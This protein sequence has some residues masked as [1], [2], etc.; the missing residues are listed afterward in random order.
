LIDSGAEVN[1]FDLEWLR[2]SGGTR[3]LKVSDRIVKSPMFDEVVDSTLDFSTVIET[4]DSYGQTKRQHL[5]GV[6]LHMDEDFEV[7]LG[8]PWLRAVNPDVDWTGATWR[9]RQV[10][11]R[12]DYLE[13]ITT[14]DELRRAQEESVATI[15][16]SNF[17]ESNTRAKEAP[18]QRRDPLGSVTYGIAGISL[19]P[20]KDMMAKFMQAI[21]HDPEEEEEASKDK[22]RPSWWTEEDEKFLDPQAADSL[23]SLGGKTHS[24]EI[25]GEIPKYSPIYPLHPKELEALKAYIEEALRKGWIRRSKSP[26]GAPIL[27]VPKKGGTLRLCIDYRQLN[28]VT[29]KDRTPLPLI[30][31]ILERLSGAIIY[32]KL[33]LKNAYYRIRIQPGDEWKTAWRCRY[34]HFEYMVMPF[35]LTNAPATFQSYIEEVLSDFTDTCCVVYLDDVLIYSKSREAHAQDVRRICERLREASLFGN[36]SKCEFET[37]STTFLGYVITP[38]GVSVDTTRVQEIRE[39][40]MPKTEMEIQAFTG[41]TNYY[42]RFIKNYSKI[43]APLHN[44]LIKEST[45]EAKEARAKEKATLSGGQLKALGK[46]RRSREIDIGPEARRAVEQLKDAF[47]EAPVLTHFQPGAPLRV[48]TDASQFAIGAVLSQLVGDQWHPVAFM[49]RKLKG[50]ELAY[51]TPDSELMA[52][53]ESFQLWRHFLAYA[54][55]PTDVRTDHLNLQHLPAKPQLSIKQAVALSMLAPYNFTITWRPGKTNPADPLSR[56]ADHYVP[57][58]VENARQAVLPGFQKR[59]QEGKPE[60]AQTRHVGS[61]ALHKGC[62]MVAQVLNVAAVRARLATGSVYM[63]PV[64]SSQRQG[65]SQQLP[66]EEA[67]LQEQQVDPWV[68]GGTWA[69]QDLPIK[70]G[71]RAE[72]LWKVDPETKL[73][74]KGA[75]IYVP[76]LLRGEVLRLC[77]DN[78]SA[79]H[80]GKARTMSR[81]RARYFWKGVKKDVEQ[82][83]R[84]CHIC[85]TTK[86]VR[87]LPYGPLQPLPV[88][89]YPFEEISM[90]FITDLPPL[91]DGRGGYVDSILVIVD[92][93]TKWV[94]YIPCSKRVD[95]A[96]LARLFVDRIYSRFG[97]PRGIVSDRGSVFTSKWWGAFCD[98]LEVKRRLSVAYHPQTDGQTERM[99]QVLEQYLRSYCAK[100]QDDWEWRLP[101]AQVAYNS[102]EHAVTKMS[103]AEALLGYKLRTPANVVGLGVT[104]A[105][106]DCDVQDRISKMED[107]RALAK[108]LLL[109]AQEYSRKRYDEGITPH[110]FKEKDWVMLRTDN[111]KLKRPSKKLAPK[112]V[113]PY[114]IERMTTS[115]NAAR[116]ILPKSTTIHPVFNV[117]SLQPYKYEEG[118]T[119]EMP[120]DDPFDPEETFE[121]EKI[122]GH[123]GNGRKRRYRIKWVGWEEPTLIVRSQFTDKELWLE[124]DAKV[125][126]KGKR[127]VGR[128]RKQ[129][130]K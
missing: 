87:Q 14:V 26:L 42:R 70:D 94:E 112:L 18:I 85:Q 27:F 21:T 8:Y 111:I 34:G 49:S 77:H 13:V 78:P 105:A 63:A 11:T 17:Q 68:R 96:E 84:F 52:I 104:E 12:F 75:Q 3:A 109:E 76:P 30:D 65:N 20:A 38:Q 4:P 100:E 95:G 44:V 125:D 123:V 45:Q 74:M 113:G 10:V 54:D 73:L 126:G 48:E 2:A 1:V 40:P 122:V 117:S 89:S 71:Q 107:D 32:T 62:L 35:G 121:I 46:R 88:P 101:L 116:L 58:E 115:G 15:Q 127:P 22:P 36:P 50:A 19:E 83:V 60:S 16:L 7:I 23:P 91:S 47:C 130:P 39:W 33:D 9:Y 69:R 61:L 97:A 118:K 56:R 51:T 119:P 128:P 114:Q 29:K 99:N 67:L 93:L 6:A 59:F 31:N 80:G 79:G 57:G 103:P 129:G 41:F 72:P 106:G 53:S 66:L 90:D 24:I 5:E 120:T 108:T 98:Y 64:S 55:V 124:Y 81:V 86:V 82:Y 43:T 28:Q 37:T 25:E 102:S 110:P 92:R